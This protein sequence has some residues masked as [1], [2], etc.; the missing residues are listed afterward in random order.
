[1]K[2]DLKAIGKKNKAHALHLRR[3]TRV[4]KIISGTKEVFFPRLERVQE[5]TSIST[6]RPSDDVSFGDG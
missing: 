4:R 1:M 6:H 3:K 5:C 2:Y